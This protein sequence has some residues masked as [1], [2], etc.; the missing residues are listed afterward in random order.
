MKSKSESLIQ[1]KFKPLAH[2][3]SGFESE[4]EFWH[5]KTLIKA[6]KDQGCKP[7]LLQL[8]SRDLSFY[9]WHD[10]NYIHVAERINRVNA[11]NTSFPIILSPAGGI[12][13]GTHRLLK[14]LCSGKTELLAVRL[15]QM[16][17]CDS[18]T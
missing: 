2:P 18:R 6:S 13:D 15:K 17:P 4:G 8:N 10:L 3:D 14:A 7:F 1:S 16:P 9:P 12:L 5:A 11:A